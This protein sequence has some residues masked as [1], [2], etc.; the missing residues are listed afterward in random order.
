M[1]YLR[2]LDGTC[3]SCQNKAVVEL[4]NCRNEPVGVYCQR[5]MNEAEASLRAS[6]EMNRRG[7]VRLWFP[8][9]IVLDVEGS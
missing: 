7:E 1:A 9:R 6:E 8:D 2:K 4:R 5:H 3:A